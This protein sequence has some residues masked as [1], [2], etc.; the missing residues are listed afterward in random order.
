M[1]STLADLFI[2]EGN[3]KE[4]KEKHRN[5]NTLD[6][7]L[8]TTDFHTDSCSARLLRPPFEAM[9]YPADLTSS[10]T[11]FILNTNFYYSYCNDV[12][13]LTS[14]TAK[15]RLTHFGKLSMEHY[16]L[17]VSIE[18]RESSAPPIV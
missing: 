10:N 4:Q 6:F 15:E 13:S 12:A 11:P 7:V 14:F 1:K 16:V 3:Q 8:R 17:A 9:F 18:E 2:I 5:C